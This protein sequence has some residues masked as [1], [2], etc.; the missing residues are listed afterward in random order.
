MRIDNANN[1]SHIR[2]MTKTT[3][4]TLHDSAFRG[5]LARLRAGSDQANQTFFDRIAAL[6]PAGRKAVDTDPLALYRLAEDAHL[7]ISEEAGRCLYLLLRS[8][9]AKRVLEFGT[10]FG[11]STLYLAAALRDN[12]GGKV[13]TCEF[14]PSKA[15]AAR[16]NLEE[17]GLIDLVEIRVG[18]ALETLKDGVGGTIDALLLDGAKQLYH[19]ILKLV[20]PWLRPGTLIAADNMDHDTVVEFARYIRDPRNGYESLNLPLKEGDSFEIAVRV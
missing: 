12:G 15:E 13:V 3:T 19:P 2:D 9:G 17:A 7:A 16:K 1:Y 6:D 5:V 4:S 8:G 20:E 11:I 10:S 18:D 14:L